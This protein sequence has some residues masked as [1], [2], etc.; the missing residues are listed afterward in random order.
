MRD[1]KILD[2]AVRLHRMSNTENN[3]F[4]NTDTAV[5]AGFGAEWHRFNQNEL[6]EFELDELFQRYFRIF[7]WED[8]AAT[9][10]GFD[11]GC[12]SGRWAK[13]VAPLVGKLHCVDPSPEALKVAK[14]NLA[15]TRNVEFHSGSANELP[16]AAGTMDFAYCLGV[17]HHAPD[18]QSGLS[19]AVSKLRQGAPFL[20]YLYYALENRPWW[21]VLIWRLA[22]V[23]RVGVSRMPFQPRYYVTQL[24]AAVVYYPLARLGKLL[25]ALGLNAS[26]L[27][28]WAY[29]S[30]SFYTM[31]TDA[32]DRFGTRLEHRFTKQEITALMKTAGLERI[33]F[34]D[35]APYWCAVGRKA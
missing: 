27:P 7:P 5:V 17:L 14:S 28:L 16:F 25:A 26:G 6:S 8:L 18:S 30:S 20:L 24:I 21:Y 13:R 11:L 4:I 2:F 19:H 33:E 35:E 29:R 3:G 1:T 32:L 12:G 10:E 34:S 23:V 15:T 9:A 31:R 22:D